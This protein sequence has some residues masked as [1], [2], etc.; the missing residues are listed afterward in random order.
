VNVLVLGDTHVPDFA[1]ALP[2]ERLEPHLAW[3]DMILH[4]GDATSAD[5]L[6]ELSAHAPV[7]AVVGNMDR[8]DVATW[9]ARHEA[10]VEIEGI[11]IAMVHDGGRREGRARR[12]AER[13]PAADV[14][15]FGHSHQPVNEDVDGVLLLNPGSPTWKRRSPHP[16]LIRLTLDAGRVASCELVPLE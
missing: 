13:F 15:V 9:G 12:L 8:P 14:I 7:V 10:Q 4:A 2:S 16:T 11:R 6:T 5:V 1:R 3:A